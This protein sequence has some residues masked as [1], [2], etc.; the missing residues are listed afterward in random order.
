MS[1]SEIIK[2]A[3]EASENKASWMVNQLAN[4][5]WAKRED[6]LIE[7][8]VGSAFRHFSV[9]A[10]N[11]ARQARSARLGEMTYSW[12]NRLNYDHVGIPI[13][14]SG[15]NIPTPQLNRV[16]DPL[17]VK[18]FTIVDI[19]YDLQELYYSSKKHLGHHRPGIKKFDRGRDLRKVE[20]IIEQAKPEAFLT[21][22]R[23]HLERSMGDLKLA[24]MTI[25]LPYIT[26]LKSDK[27]KAVFEELT[28][29]QEAMSEASI[30][31]IAFQD[32]EAEQSLLEEHHFDYLYSI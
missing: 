17:F 19:L 27:R 9:V 24:G 11:I 6:A 25:C 10:G 18:A 7:I 30:N 13:V 26:R 21:K 12:S 32:Q 4:E 29:L 14:C 8:N 2:P 5:E 1:G 15:I 16:D 31:L 3:I 23:E 22:M 28:H 20:W